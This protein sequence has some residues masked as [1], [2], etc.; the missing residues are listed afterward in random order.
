MRPELASRAGVLAYRDDLAER[1]DR[2][3]LEAGDLGLDLV[4]DRLVELRAKV[5]A[6]L[7]R[8]ALG[9]ADVLVLP[10][11]RPRP[12]LVIA[13]DRYEDAGREA[14]IIARNKVAY[15]LF[16]PGP[17]EVMSR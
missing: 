11:D 10:L 9:L 1:L 2:A 16:V 15:P 3:I 7:T 12:A 4:Y 13:Y 6:D 5:I 14:E 17:V 8:R